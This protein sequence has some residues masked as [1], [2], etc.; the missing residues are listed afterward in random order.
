MALTK[1]LTRILMFFLIVS[2]AYAQSATTYDP[3]VLPGDFLYPIKVASERFRIA[4][5]PN[6]EN[7][8]NLRISYLERRVAEMQKLKEKGRIKD[9][10]RADQEHARLINELKDDDSASEESHKRA[11]EVIKHSET[12]LQGLIEKFRE[13]K[14][15]NNDNAIKALET[16]VMRSKA[17]PQSYTLSGRGKQKQGEPI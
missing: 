7:A 13:D 12:V 9:F 6:K 11:T 5:T 3:S 16:A 4:F 2:S 1:K 10:D 8:Y 17:A 15:P 14:N